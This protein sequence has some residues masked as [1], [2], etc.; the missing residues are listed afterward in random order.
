MKTTQF[1]L[2]I[3]I[4]FLGFS[5]C[6]RSQSSKED[7]TRFVKRSVDDRTYVYDTL[8]REIQNKNNYIYKIKEDFYCEFHVKTIKPYDEIFDEIFPEARKKELKG[9]TLPMVFYHDASGN[10]L[11]IRFKLKDISMITLK[12]LK[13]LEDAFLEKQKVEIIN[14]CP[15]K[16]YYRLVGVY[17]GWL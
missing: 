10:L 9:L 15:E 7:T 2:I 17:R 3:M 8:Y 6:L 1:I 16:K 4:C 14:P 13:A 5:T 11:E 12:E